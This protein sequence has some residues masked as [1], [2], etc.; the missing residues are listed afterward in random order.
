[1]I[2]LT[3]PTSMLVPSR[4]DDMSSKPRLF[5]GCGED[6]WSG[7]GFADKDETLSLAAAAQPQ[8]HPLPFL[9]V[10]ACCGD[11]VNAEPSWVDRPIASGS[12]PIALGPAVSSPGRH[13]ITRT[14]PI[15]GTSA[16]AGSSRS[17][18]LSNTTRVD[19]RK[20]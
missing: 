18:H 16:N 11:F 10:A 4:N 6:S 1:V 12:L 19:Q 5:E 9:R 17:I 14:T 20:S 7:P 3:S 15:A 2:E 8:P 13:P